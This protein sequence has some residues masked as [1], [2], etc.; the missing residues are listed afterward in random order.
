MNRRVV[1]VGMLLA[2]AG[3]GGLKGKEDDLP[4]QVRR[5]NEAVRWQ[6]YEAA[7]AFVPI[8]RREAFVDAR[9]KEAANRRLANYAVRRV[10]Q[11][12]L[13]RGEAIVVVETAWYGLADPTVVNELRYQR[14]RFDKRRWWMV[15]ETSE[16][17]GPPAA[18]A[19]PA[20]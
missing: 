5:F 1:V 20:E 16:D 17:P 10:R 9:Q 19:P 13:P 6:N 18:P 3:C 7:A 2:L 15:E 4:E 11:G 14:W 12:P 8:E